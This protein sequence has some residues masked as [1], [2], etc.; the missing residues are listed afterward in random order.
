MIDNSPRENAPA[1]ANRG[2]GAVAQGVRR[3]MVVG[4]GLNIG[5]VRERKGGIFK[6]SFVLGQARGF[7][8]DLD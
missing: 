3:A 4:V 2:R 6:S 7:K 8:P 1:A 5:L